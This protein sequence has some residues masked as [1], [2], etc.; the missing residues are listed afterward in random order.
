MCSFT[1]RGFNN[2]SHYFYT[3][4][5]PPIFDPKKCTVSSLLSAPS[6]RIQKSLVNFV[7]NFHSQGNCAVRTTF[8]QFHSQKN[9]HSL[10][11]SFVMLSS[12]FLSEIWRRTFAN[13]FSG[14]SEFAFAFAAVS[15]RPRCTQF[16]CKNTKLPHCT[17]VTHIPP[18]PPQ[19][20]P[21]NSRPT[22]F[23]ADFLPLYA[24]PLRK[25]VRK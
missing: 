1:S 25:R 21:Q 20:H 4:K 19:I 9:S 12:Q 14:A 7:A 15:L 18:P 17:Y 23:H 22:F 24:F 13:E 6:H 16:P 5:M 11:N 3:A 10:A 8:S 2:L